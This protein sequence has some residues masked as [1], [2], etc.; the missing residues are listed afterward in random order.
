MTSLEP[1]ASSHRVVRE[2]SRLWLSTAQSRE[3]PRPDDDGATESRLETPHALRTAA[4]KQGVIARLVAEVR[5][6]R[7]RS[8]AER[9][10][11]RST[12]CRAVPT[13]RHRSGSTGACQG[14]RRSRSATRDPLVVI[15][16]SSTCSTIDVQTRPSAGSRPAR[17]AAYAEHRATVSD[18]A[19]VAPDQDHRRRAMARDVG[20]G[21]VGD[22]PQVLAWRR[23]VLDELG[24]ELALHERVAT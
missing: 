6:S 16:G 19:L 21:R 2:T 10:G 23:N 18:R 5:R 12:R 11:R 20:A 22:Q 4:A 13:R 8:V 9:A 1:R 24:A 15:P 17:L 7:N 3:R 14:A